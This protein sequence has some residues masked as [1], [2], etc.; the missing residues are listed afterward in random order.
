M[1]RIGT[2]VIGTS[3]AILLL[4]LGLLDGTKAQHNRFTGRA[5]ERDR[6]R[7]PVC[8]L[9]RCESKRGDIG[10]VRRRRGRKLG[11]HETAS[12]AGLV[13]RSPT[14]SRN[15]PPDHNCTRSAFYAWEAN[16]LGRSYV[17]N[18]ANSGSNSP[19]ASTFAAKT[20]PSWR[21]IS[22]WRRWS[23]SP[24]HLFFFHNLPPSSLCLSTL[25]RAIS[26]TAHSLTT[27]ALVFDGDDIIFLAL[28]L[29]NSKHDEKTSDTTTTTTTTIIIIPAEQQRIVRLL[30]A[31]FINSLTS[32]HLSA[33]APS[34]DEGEPLVPA[35][36]LCTSSGSATNLAADADAELDA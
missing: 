10:V 4:R 14:D 16:H 36:C 22:L 15:G 31:H 32:R 17:D 27:L 20:L 18:V 3:P 35:R 30:L 28:L 29:P 2:P 19:W 24:R 1:H 8:F 13:C 34:F 26:S 12:R 7:Y 33:S 9:K 6:R 21:T 5:R 25:R 23:K 11:E